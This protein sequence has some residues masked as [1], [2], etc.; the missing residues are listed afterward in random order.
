MITYLK[1]NY[2]GAL[3]RHVGV[4]Y[5]S[6]ISCI[7]LYIWT[8]DH[9]R[10]PLHASPF[11]LILLEAAVTAALIK[12]TASLIVMFQMHQR[13]TVV[14]PV[15]IMCNVSRPS[16]YKYPGVCLQECNCIRLVIFLFVKIISR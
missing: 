15:R 7:Y 2:L 6:R 8:P 3:A 5:M 16:Y 14:A 1:F 10:C 13:D 4:Y 9:T 12:C 11:T